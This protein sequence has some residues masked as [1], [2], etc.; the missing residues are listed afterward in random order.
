L[1]DHRRT[2]HVA[3]C[4]SNCS[5][6]AYNTEAAYRAG[7]PTIRSRHRMG[8]AALARPRLSATRT[9]QRFGCLRCLMRVRLVERKKRA[10]RSTSKSKASPQSQ[11][12]C[13][14]T[15]P[16]VENTACLPLLT[17]PRA[18][19]RSLDLWSLLCPQSPYVD[20]ID[21]DLE[22]CAGRGEWHPHPRW[23][24]CRQRRPSCLNRARPRMKENC[25]DARIETLRTANIK[26]AE[27][28]RL[29]Y[30]T[31]DVLVPA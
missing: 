23:M 10:L 31:G 19:S 29:S 22:R 17:H 3:H 15:L 7:P 18:V 20:S 27:R 4:L 13:D 12:R 8:H 5:N 9:G 1:H 30:A 11:K 14:K 25:F 24:L 28:D 2:H 21:C 6:F 16:A 26:T